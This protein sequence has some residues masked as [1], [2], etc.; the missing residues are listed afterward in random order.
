MSH[1]EQSFQIP[2]QGIH[3][4]ALNTADLDATIRFYRDVLGM[5]ASDIAPSQEGRGRHCLILVKPN[6][7]NV[8]G[9]HFFERTIARTT[10]GASD[11]HPQSFVPHVALRLPNGNAVQALRERLSY[12]HVSVTEIPEL[13]TFVFFDN[14]GLCLEVTWPKGEHV[15]S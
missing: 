2:W 5:Q 10:L 3:H 11:T 15:S 9:F 4:I 8:W 1:T 13:G 12:A 14:N 6:D 7:D